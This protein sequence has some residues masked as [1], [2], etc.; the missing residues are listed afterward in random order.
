MKFVVTYETDLRENAI[1]ALKAKGLT[2][3]LP[4]G[5]IIKM[6]QKTVKHIWIDFDGTLEELEDVVY[7]ISTERFTGLRE[8]GDKE[9]LFN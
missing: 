3:Q 9:A 8:L 2:V 5:T 1:S 4:P 6:I 7:P